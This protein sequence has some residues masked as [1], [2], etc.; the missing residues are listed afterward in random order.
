MQHL[1]QV[2]RKVDYALRAMIYLASQPDGTR[3]PLQDI[4]RKN[5]IPREFLA[6]ILKTLGD[7]GLVTA[8]RGPGGGVSI[9]RPASRVSFLDVIEAIEGPVVLNLCLD[10]S[11]SCSQAAMCTMQS[12]WKAGQERMLDV[13]RTTMLS[14]LASQPQ[15]PVP[16]G[17]SRADGHVRTAL[18]TD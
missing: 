16:L 10:D 7:R 3:E 2:S 14:D 1:L 5:G 18:P 17:T 4:A 12:V 15:A 8:L 13:Y 6:K 9:A 11:K